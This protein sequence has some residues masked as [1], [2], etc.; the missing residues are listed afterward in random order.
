MTNVQS[1]VEGEWFKF[2]RVFLTQTQRELL[3]SQNPEDEEAKFTLMEEIKGLRYTALTTEESEKYI[4]LY[5]KNKPTLVE[6]DV[7]EL[8]S[9]DISFERKTSGII[10]CRVNGDHKQIRF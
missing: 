7:Y 1:T 9:C 10:N 4:E 3:N 5:N 8:I 6:S 2:N